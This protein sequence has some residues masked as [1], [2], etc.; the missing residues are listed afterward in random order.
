MSYQK[1]SLGGPNSSDEESLLGGPES[2]DDKPLTKAQ[3]KKILH[4][5]AHRRLK[6]RTYIAGWVGVVGMTLVLLSLATSAYFGYRVLIAKRYLIILWGFVLF[7]VLFWGACSVWFMHDVRTLQSP[8]WLQIDIGRLAFS[9]GAAIGLLI[10]IHVKNAQGPDPGTF[11]L[12]CKSGCSFWYS[13]YMY[14]PLAV[15]LINLLIGIIQIW[16]SILVYN[17]HIVQDPWAPAGESDEEAP[18]PPPSPPLIS[19]KEL[20]KHGSS[21]GR[22]SR[23]S[24][25]SRKGKERAVDQGRSGRR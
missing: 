25:G 6:R 8:D 10:A 18:P 11:N 9:D 19:E 7:L 17:D 12:G 21:K 16:V 3:E 14:S 22:K 13:S 24:G 20:G 23:R 15:A 4:S 5:P 1:A 2:D